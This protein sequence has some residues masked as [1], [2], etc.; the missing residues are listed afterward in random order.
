MVQVQARIFTDDDSFKISIDLLTRE[1]ANE[2]E[3]ELAQAIERAFVNITDFIAKENGLTL[4]VSNP[5]QGRCD[6]D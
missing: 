2:T 4:E 1:D 6:G 3:K 5:L